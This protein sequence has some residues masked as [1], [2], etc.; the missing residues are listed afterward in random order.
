M[1]SGRYCRLCR[2]CGVSDNFRRWERRYGGMKVPDARRLKQ[3]EEENQQQKRIVADPALKLHVRT[4]W[5]KCG[6]S[7]Q[8]ANRGHRGERDRSDFGTKSVL[9]YRICHLHAALSVM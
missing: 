9:L 8:A 7:E 1:G 3:I 5:E 2:R 4:R 6:D